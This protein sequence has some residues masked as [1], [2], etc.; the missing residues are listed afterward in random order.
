MALTRKHFQ[1][2]ADILACHRR[3]IESDTMSRDR[4]YPAIVADF[5]RYFRGEN[6]QFD[7]GRFHRACNP[8]V[9]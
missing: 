4:V 3:D 1:A 9:N 5:A 6:G 8:E 7:V 2:V